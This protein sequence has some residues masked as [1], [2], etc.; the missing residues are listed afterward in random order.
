MPITSK[1]IPTKQILTSPIP[2]NPTLIIPI[3]T[4]PI[5]TNPIGTSPIE[6][7]PRGAIPI[8]TSLVRPSGKWLVLIDCSDCELEDKAIHLNK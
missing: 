5:A 3:D 8:E 6:I 4:P 7:I 1:P 2:T